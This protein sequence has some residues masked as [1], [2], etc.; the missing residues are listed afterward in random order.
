MS[1][2]DFH[3]IIAKKSLGQNFLQDTSILSA[4]AESIEIE[5][6]NIIEVGPW[7]GALTEYILAKNPKSLELIEFD[8]DMV[9]ILEKRRILDW[10]NH[11]FH[12]H[13]GDVL[14]FLPLK[15][16]YSVIANIPYYITSP[17]LFHFLHPNFAKKIKENYHFPKKMT[18]LMQKEVWEK[19]LAS[20]KKNHFSYL[21]LAMHLAC[22]NIEIVTYAP[23][24]AFRPAPKVDSIALKFTTRNNRN[25]EIEKKLLNFWNICFKHP[26][27]T[28]VSN[29][30]SAWYEKQKTID[31]LE[32]F[33]YSP[34]VRAE[35]INPN[36]WE[37]IMMQ[38]I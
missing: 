20:G 32:I 34:S 36:D 27:K 26:R 19:I 38:I 13:H 14:N 21:S 3:K 31:I 4:I 16:E 12:I 7:Y 23:K 11:N 22:E 28:L 37:D 5:N 33:N 1:S 9:Q 17:I 2:L 8:N 15:T 18:I 25:F 24:N 30:V 6:E 10:N 35:A 29:L